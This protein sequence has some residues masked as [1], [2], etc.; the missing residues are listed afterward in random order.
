MEN[1]TEQQLKQL[2][3]EAALASVD[4]GQMEACEFFNAL[5]EWAYANAE[6]MLIDPGADEEPEDDE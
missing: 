4:M 2:T 3:R 6:A 1:K 5:A